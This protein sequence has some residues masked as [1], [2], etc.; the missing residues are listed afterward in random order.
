MLTAGYKLIQ[1]INS[2][3]PN[4]FLHNFTYNGS[5][6]NRPIIIA[7]VLLSFL[8]NWSY[9]TFF[10]AFGTAPSS[11]DCLNKRIS[12]SFNSPDSSFK[13]LGCNL[14]GPGDLLTFS[15]LLRNY[16]F[17][18]INILKSQPIA[19]ILKKWKVIHILFG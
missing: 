1:V 18:N 4:Y 5:Q 19:S 13:I 8:E 3:C 14:S 16:T 6:T 7:Y 10:Q 15:Q 9:F 11:S 2:L 17:L 12:G